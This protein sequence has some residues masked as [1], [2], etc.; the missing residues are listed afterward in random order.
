MISSG[1]TDGMW[2][3]KGEQ[4]NLQKLIIKN[5]CV[6]ANFI[7]VKVTYRKTLDNGSTKKVNELYLA[8]AINVKEAEDR[9]LQELSPYVI[10]ISD[11]DGK[12]SMQIKVACLLSTA[13][14]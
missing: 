5:Q 10:L 1:L 2:L 3:I 13:A 8:D 7:E 14:L 11:K 9:V 6:V 4:T 12:P